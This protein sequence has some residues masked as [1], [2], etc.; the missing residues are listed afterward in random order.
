MNQYAGNN[1]GIRRV[2]EVFKGDSEFGTITL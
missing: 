2:A 1:N